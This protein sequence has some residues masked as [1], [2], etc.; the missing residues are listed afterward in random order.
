MTTTA[1]PPPLELVQSSEG[2]GG[3]LDRLLSAGVDRR[4]FL[5]YC[6]AITATL[7]LPPQF[8]P[9]VAHALETVQRPSLVWLEFQDCAGDTES[10]LRA[11]S[12]SV[13]ELILDVLSLDYHETIM[14]TA[15]FQ[16]EKSRDDTIAKGGH[17]VVVEGSIPLGADGGLPKAAPNPTRAV[18]VDEVVS[19][20]PIVNL[21]GCPMN[22]DNLNATIAHY[23]TFKELPARDQKGRPLFAYG[24]RIHDNCPRR[25]H[26]DAGQ[27]ALEWGDEG[28]RKGWCLY[29]LGCKGPSTWHN[30]PIVQWNGSTNWPVGVGH[31]C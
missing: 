2:A 30:C 29:R 24:E 25:G 27:F 31:G 4:T 7:A 22:V 1:G 19:G 13:A 3:L 8:A 21:P 11:S 15:G 17:I 10:L 6:A 20:V 28:H 9:K 26:F 14:A 12:P 16:A 23:L 5:K 18:P